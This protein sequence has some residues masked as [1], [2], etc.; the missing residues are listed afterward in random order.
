MMKQSVVGSG[1]IRIPGNSDSSRYFLGVK[2]TS[3][4]LD[5]LTSKLTDRELSIDSSDFFL[6]FTLNLGTQ[7]CSKFS[8]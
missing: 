4:C 2:F 8:L 3:L 5:N 1:P 6:S 7:T